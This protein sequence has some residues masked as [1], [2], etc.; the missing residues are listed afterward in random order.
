METSSW[1]DSG[2]SDWM[3][4]FGYSFFKIERHSSSDCCRASRV[5]R[6]G[7][8]SACRHLVKVELLPRGYYSLPVLVI[9]ARLWRT[10]TQALATR[11]PSVA[12]NLPSLAFSASMRSRYPLRVSI[13]RGLRCVLGHLGNR[14]WWS[15]TLDCSNISGEE[16]Q[17][18][19]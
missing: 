16:R 1:R 15:K 18:F 12:P 2:N 10:T 14:S 11:L 13:R 7:S 8:V 4:V 19:V 9:V 6:E 3:S 17:T 5:L